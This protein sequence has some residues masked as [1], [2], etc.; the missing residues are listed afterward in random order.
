VK[1]KLAAKTINDSY[2]ASIRALLQ[3]GL[4]NKVLADNVAK[5][6]GVRAPKQA[7]QRRLA[8]S[9]DEVS[10]LLQVV[11]RDGD[12]TRRWLIWLTAATG[13]RVGEI[14][15]LW[16]EN[17]VQEGVQW[18]LY[19]RPAPDGGSLKN[20]G[21]ERVVPLHPSLIDEGF[22][23]FVASKKAGPLFYRRSSGDPQRKHAAK[24][25]ANHLAAWIRKQGFEDPR[26]APNHALRHWWKSAAVQAEIAEGMAD[27]LQGHAARSEADGYRHYDVEQLAAKIALIPLPQRQ[28]LRKPS[29]DRVRKCDLL[30]CRCVR[31]N[32]FGVVTTGLQESSTPFARLDA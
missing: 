16:A 29:R 27:H 24:G 14:A 15:Q 13:A 8:Y 6:I 3:F 18:V 4:E 12:P 7:G 22:L 17:V 20:E 23:D 32:G 28:R 26:K 5:G 25:V 2:I 30:F 21:S 31:G 1:Q 11:K 10:R 9:N 19:I